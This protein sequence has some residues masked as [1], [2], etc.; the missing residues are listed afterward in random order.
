MKDWIYNRIKDAEQCIHEELHICIKYKKAKDIVCEN[1][2]KKVMSRMDAKTMPK[3]YKEQVSAILW[4][5]WKREVSNNF[6]FPVLFEG[7]LYSEWDAM[8]D[9]CK[10]FVMR[11]DSG[12]KNRPYPV[13]KWHFKEGMKG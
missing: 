7:R 4:F 1:I 12:T 2:R 3:K 5:C 9:E 11:N 6:I 10:E 8:P 13:F